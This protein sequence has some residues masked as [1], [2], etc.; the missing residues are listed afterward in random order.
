MGLEGLVR[1][2]FFVNVFMLAGWVYVDVCIRKVWFGVC[3]LRTDFNFLFVSD[4]CKMSQD[5]DVSFLSS[6]LG[7]VV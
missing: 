6:F 1:M 4:M 7:D 2:G 5:G 3:V